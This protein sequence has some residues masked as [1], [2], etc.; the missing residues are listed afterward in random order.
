MKSRER[1]IQR[2]GMLCLIVILS[3][4]RVCCRGPVPE[5]FGTG[6]PDHRLLGAVTDRLAFPAVWLE[7]VSSNGR[8]FALKRE[9]K[10]S[11]D[12]SNASS[13]WIW[14]LKGQWTP[15]GMNE[16]ETNDPWNR[17]WFIL[18]EWTSDTVGTELATLM[19]DG[20]WIQIFINLIGA[21]WITFRRLVPT[22][23][24]INFSRIIHLFSICANFHRLVQSTV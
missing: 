22:C 16:I 19:A 17:R 7:D 3:S 1:N 14:F 21:S 20:C 5:H 11:F 24:N 18:V 9:K 6:E 8:H 4:G 23:R 13:T 10:F 2:L 15:R 12:P